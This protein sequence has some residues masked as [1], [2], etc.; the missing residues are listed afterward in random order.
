MKPALGEPFIAKGVNIFAGRNENVDAIVSYWPNK[1]DRLQKQ[2]AYFAKRYRDNPYVWFE[3]TNEPETSGS[4]TASPKKEAQH[5]L[6][7]NK[8]LIQTIRETGNIN[9]ILIQGWC[10][11]QVPVTGP[12]PK[13]Q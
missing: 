13:Y 10:W 3:T 6:N 11:G 4:L 12:V 7:L 8:T 9:P 2:Y 1:L 5:W